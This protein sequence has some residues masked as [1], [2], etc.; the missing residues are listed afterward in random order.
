[1]ASAFRRKIRE[2]SFRLK[3]EATRLFTSA[4][5]GCSAKSYERAWQL[6]E[7]NSALRTEADTLRA[8]VRTL[9]R[10]C[11]DDERHRSLR[12]AARRRRALAD[13]R[14]IAIFGAGEGGRRHA[15]HWRAGG[16]RVRC[17]T[18]NRQ[19]LWGSELEGVPIIAP[20]ELID[21]EAALI[22]IGSS[23]GVPEIV[24]QLEELG[25]VEEVDFVRGTAAPHS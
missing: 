4:K 7:E 11:A 19:D 1:V 21:T 12:L 24:R 5:D 25:F 16:G 23:I 13:P 3:P 15:A 22:V 8:Q 10:A 2:K 14:G 9:E 6:D 20:R 18:D 17:F